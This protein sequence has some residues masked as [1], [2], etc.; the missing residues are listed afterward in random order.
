MAYVVDNNILIPEMQAM[1]RAG[2]QVLFTPGGVSMRPFIEGGRDS[3]V[4]TMCTDPKVG[5]M[6][7]CHTGN[8]YVLH[9]LIL[10]DGDHLTL[11]GDGNIGS[12]E[13]CTTADIVG[14]V[15]DI[16][17]PSGRHKPVTR[18]RIWYHLRPMR[19]YLLKI[20]RHTVVPLF[21]KH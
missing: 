1:I 5:D 12:T 18:G 8:R 19:R 21:I 10:R 16:L 9:R 6:L 3:V 14:R 2:Q 20:Y 11:M 13:Q 7:L 17:T 15:V 4:L